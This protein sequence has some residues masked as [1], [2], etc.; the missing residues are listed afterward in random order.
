MS[1]INPTDDDVLTRCRRLLNDSATDEQ[2]LREA[3]A[4]LSEALRAAS[5]H[6]RELRSAVLDVRHA[7]TP[8]RA[9]RR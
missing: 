3:E 5:H 2:E 8:E 6:V 1:G 9:W 4:E 7:L